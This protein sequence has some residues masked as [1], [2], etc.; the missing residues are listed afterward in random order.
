MEIDPTVERALRRSAVD[1]APDLLGWTF[2][3]MVDGLETAVRLTEVEAYMGNDDPASHAYRGETTRTAPMFMSAGV[4][5]VYLV[6]GVH[7]CVNVVTGVEGAAQAV[8]LRG[9]VPVAGIDVMER[10]RGRPSDLAS[11]PG[12]LG[13]ALGI[14]TRHSGIPIDGSLV[15]LEPGPPPPTIVAATRVGIS[16]GTDRLWRFVAG[17]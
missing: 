8:L 2:S 11:G 15:R 10:R 14:T 3:T 17:T 13:Q 4:I 5:Y 16:R 1:V 9:G 12:R 7:H 6:Y